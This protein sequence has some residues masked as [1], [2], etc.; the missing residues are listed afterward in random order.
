MSP[1][2]LLISPSPFSLSSLF[3]SLPSSLPLGRNF[4][5]NI[6]SWL[7]LGQ[8]EEDGRWAD[9]QDARDSNGHYLTLD[10][11]SVR[12]CWPEVS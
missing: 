1:P 9:S 8:R 2:T 5:N 4:Y 6:D 12:K 11:Q 3:F 10:G 7:W